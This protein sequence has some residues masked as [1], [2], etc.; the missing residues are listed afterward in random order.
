MAKRG[1]AVVQ[2]ILKV[3]AAEGVHRPARD[4]VVVV[5]AVHRPPARL[6]EPGSE[7]PLRQYAGKMAE[8]IV[9]RQVCAAVDAVEQQHMRAVFRLG[10]RCV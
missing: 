7:S 4:I 9:R 1:G 8:F 5:F 10:I 2:F 6:A 3:F